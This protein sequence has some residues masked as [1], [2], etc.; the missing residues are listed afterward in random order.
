MRK[1]V[2]AALA[3]CLFS[4]AIAQ[5]TSP[6]GTGRRQGARRG[7]AAGYSSRDATVLSMMGWGLGLAVGMAALCALLDDHKAGSG[8][9]VHSS[10]H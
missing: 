3:V 7:E 6:P 2:S 1:L 4:S 5:E 10:S 9:N 8:S